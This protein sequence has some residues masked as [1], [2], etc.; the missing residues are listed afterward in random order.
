MT[1]LRV[2]VD[3]LLHGLAEGLDLQPAFAVEVAHLLHIERVVRVERQRFDVLRRGAGLLE[4]GE[5]D[6]GRELHRIAHPVVPGLRA[7]G[8]STEAGHGE[9]RHVRGAARLESVTVRL[10]A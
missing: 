5:R 7:R 3:A 8:E 10:H 9:E 6:I 4:Q 2:T 1:E